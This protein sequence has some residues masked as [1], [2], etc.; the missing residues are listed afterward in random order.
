MNDVQF[1]E[2]ARHLAG[3]AL[4]SAPAGFDQQ[5]DF[6][7]AHLVARKFE[8][9]ERAVSKRAYQDFLRFYDGKPAE[10]GKLIAQGESRPNPSL[11][12]AELAAMTMLANQLMNL[13]EVLNK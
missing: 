5:L 4:E 3:R 2:A 8:E 9:R 10:A 7:T 6:L 1:V 13:D 12:P 11:S